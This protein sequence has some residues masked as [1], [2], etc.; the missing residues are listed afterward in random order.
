M[1]YFKT[2]FLIDTFSNIPFSFF[3]RSYKYDPKLYLIFM[4]LKLIRVRK[5][6]SG[7]KKLVRKLGFGVVTIRF[8]LTLWNIFMM[9]HLTACLWGTIG[10]INL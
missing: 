4:S 10:E 9:L 2:W 7:L 6:H 8:S 3:Y 1:N 5:A